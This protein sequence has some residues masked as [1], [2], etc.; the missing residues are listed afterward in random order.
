MALFT[1]RDLTAISVIVI[2][3]VSGWCIRFFLNKKDMEKNGV[4]VYQEVI[5]VPET[6]KPQIPAENDSIAKAAEDKTFK[7]VNLN[8]AGQSELESLPFIG[9]KKAK[10]I[11][12]Y[13]DKNGNFKNTSDIVKVKG[14]GKA[15]YSKIKDYI[16]V[17]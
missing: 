17:K 4:T 1:K 13:R 10:E 6:M 12:E 14:I 11:I 7:M 2:L 3:I 8:T 15:T 9:Q 16:T 5:P